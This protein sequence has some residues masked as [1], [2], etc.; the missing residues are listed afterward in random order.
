VRRIGGRPPA[1]GRD[2]RKLE[3]YGGLISARAHSSCFAARRAG[4]GPG[5]MTTLGCPCGKAQITGSVHCARVA[6]PEP[7]VDAA[8]E[9]RGS[10]YPPIPPGDLVLGAIWSLTAGGPEVTSWTWLRGNTTT[11]DERRR[12]RGRRSERDRR[13]SPSMPRSARRPLGG[14][15]PQPFAALPQPRAGCCP[16]RRRSTK[17][18]SSS[19]TERWSGTRCAAALSPSPTLT[20]RSPDAGS[21]A[22]KARSSVT[23]S[24]R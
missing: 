1:G 2:V 7:G 24:P 8:P 10:G 14:V 15:R 4:M 17:S 21:S 6:Q 18:S 11:R 19:T 23:S 20:V 12:K 16:A 9:R 22:A 5:T 3:V 13:P